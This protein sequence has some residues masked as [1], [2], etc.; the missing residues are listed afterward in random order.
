V[1]APETPSSDSTSVAQHARAA[2][3]IS[4]LRGRT[5]EMEL[6]ISGLTT[7]ALLALPGWLLGRYVEI[8]PHLSV[9]SAVGAEVGLTV[10]S[11]LCYALGACFVAHLLARAYWVGLI[12]LRAAFPAG[13]DWERTPGIGPLQRDYYRRYLPDLDGGGGRGLRRRRCRQD[14]P[15]HRS[16]ATA[17]P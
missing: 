9:A 11:G 4:E 14:S 13:I 2:Q 17:W 1:G 8:C 7:F 12:G 10:V 15:G 5:D 3:P 16:R 6:I